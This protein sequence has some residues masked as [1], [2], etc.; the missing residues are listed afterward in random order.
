MHEVFKIAQ[1]W[2]VKDIFSIPLFLIDAYQYIL[3]C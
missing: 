2:F 3:L 1:K